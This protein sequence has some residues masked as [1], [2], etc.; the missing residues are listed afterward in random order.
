M[1]DDKTKI[2][3]NLRQLGKQL[4]HGLA[5]L[6]PPTEENLEAVR[7]LAR[8]HWEQKQKEQTKGGTAAHS[9]THERQQEKSTGEAKEAESPPKR[10]ASDKD[11]G[12]SF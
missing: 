8:R 9:S 12:Q 5:K 2:E 7:A 10:K 1:T 11:I 3:E 4:R 6:H